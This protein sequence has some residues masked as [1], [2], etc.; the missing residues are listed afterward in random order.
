MLT[1]KAKIMFLRIM[2]DRLS[3]YKVGDGRWEM[4][5]GR[6]DMGDGTRIFIFIDFDREGIWRVSSI[7]FTC[8]SLIMFSLR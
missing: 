1:Y 5:D 7:T 3:I 8:L 6:W 4:G 2:L